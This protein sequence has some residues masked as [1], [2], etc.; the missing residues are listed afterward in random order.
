MNTINIDG[1]EYGSEN[2][3]EVV[4]MDPTKLLLALYEYRTGSH[5]N[6]DGNLRCPF[7][8][9]DSELMHQLDGFYLTNQ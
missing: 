1:D 2:L 5:Q 7:K 3:V 8:N 6:D 4:N 9:V